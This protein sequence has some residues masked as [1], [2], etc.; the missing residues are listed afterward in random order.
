[1]AD[2]VLGQAL[3]EAVEEVLERMFFAETLG[4]ARDAH[5]SADEVAV[6]LSFAGEPAGAMHLRLTSSAA[7]E[8]A[9]DFLGMD[10]AEIADT[11]VSE[12]IRELANMICGSFLSRVESAATFH[13]SVPRMVSP[14]EELPQDASNTRCCVQLANGRLTVNI[15]AEIPIC[16]RPVPSAY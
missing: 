9:A 3:R 1:V 8:I 2:I 16:P 13:L 4:E 5:P 11:Q 15:A 6:E 14:G 12:V 7:G 10:A